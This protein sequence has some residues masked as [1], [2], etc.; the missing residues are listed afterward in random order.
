MNKWFK[1]GKSILL[2]L[3]GLIIVIAV[4]LFLYYQSIYKETP[5]PTEIAAKPSLAKNIGASDKPILLPIPKKLVWTSGYFKL[6]NLLTFSAPIEEIETIKKACKNRFNTEGVASASGI[7]KCIKNPTL[8]EQSYI[9]NI[10]PSQIKVEYN[11]L[12]GLFYAMTTVKQ[13]ANQTNNQLPCVQIEDAPDMKTRGAMLDISRG[14]IPTLGTLY[15]IVDFL[16]DVKYNQLQLYIESFPFAYPSFKSLWEK[17]ETPLTPEEIKQLDA[18]CK[19]RFI[20]LVPNQNSLGHMQAWLK[21]DEYKDLAECPE[22][23]KLL[24]LIEMKTTMSP[25]NPKTLELVKKMSEDLLPNFT[26]NKFNVNLD[27]PF[28]LGKSKKRPISDPKE[29]AKLYIDYAKQLN[30]YVNSKGKT[31]MMWGDV[32]T[33][34]PEIIPEI[35]KNITLLEWGYE[36]IH[37]FE[38]NCA[39]YQKAGLH[40]LVCPGTS[41]WSSF[42]GRTDNM[43]SNVENAITNGIKY[44]ADGMLITDWGD[45]PHL[46][47]WTVSYAG[48]AYAA[49]LS[50]NNESKNQVALGGYLSKNAF[51]DKSN[52]MGDLVLEMGRYDQF[53][54]YPTVS[55][56][57]TGMAYRFGMMDKMM[58]DA[59][60][61]KLKTGIFDLLPPDETLKKHFSNRFNNPKIYNTKA[62][63]EFVD[64]L[65]KQLTEVHLNR[66]DSTLIVDEYKNG[67]RM[68]ALG[69]KLKQFNNYHLQQTDAENKT[70]LSEMKI[71]CLTILTEHKRLWLS[72]NKSG[73]Y[74]TSTEPINKLELQINDNLEML[75]KNVVSRWFNRSKE[76]IITAAA[77]L[78]LK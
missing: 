43:M 38:K 40:Y 74:E 34:T 70:L 30:E 33:K 67:L 35:P 68:V 2:G 72:R 7:L 23:Y 73:G 6:P 14:K 60:D 25:T 20:E 51:N 52:K 46:Q 10:Q 62:I 71:L 9:L 5:L 58:L 27:E 66:P 17:T 55:M 13:L 36:D 44:G 42:T 15:G 4:G 22:G 77:V 21:T 28:E 61:K 56:T 53:E 3:F 12:Q 24:G 50:W 26:S 75:D 32:V 69:A 18:Y 54:E 19:E 65:E 37:P 63:L 57:T 47:Y 59:I 11:D 16:S 45:T 49:A 31:M 64:N 29:V 78:Y 76:K 39:M 8:Q 48:L 41:S 1:I